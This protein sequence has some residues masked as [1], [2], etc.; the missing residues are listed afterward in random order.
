MG[1]RQASGIGGGRG[2]GS[3]RGGDSWQRTSTL[4]A[5]VLGL[6]GVAVPS[7]DGGAMNLAALLGGDGG[8]QTQ[9]NPLAGVLIGCVWRAE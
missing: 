6:G 8:L 4:D 9:I 7:L 1:R 5:S 3:K 2:A